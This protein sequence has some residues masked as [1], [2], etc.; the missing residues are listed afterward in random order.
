MRDIEIEPKEFADRLDRVTGT[1]WRP[2]FIDAISEF[3]A[4]HGVGA[5]HLISVE[6]S[7]FGVVN[8]SVGPTIAD[9]VLAK[10]AHRL[11]KIFPDAVAIG[12]LH[13]DHFALAFGQ[14]STLAADVQKLID[15]MQRPFA[16]NG[17]VIVLSVRVGAADAG[18]GVEDPLELL[19]AAE[20]ALHQT[21]ADMAKV[22]FFNADML[23]KAK[24][25]HQ[26]ENDLRL[27]LAM[28]AAELHRALNDFEFF[29]A[30]QPII[31]IDT[32]MVHAMEALL[33]W[34]H[35]KKGLVPPDR[36]I[37]LAEDIYVMDLLGGWV[38]RRACTDAAFWPANPDGTTPA[39]SI[40][41]SKV[42]FQNADM[43]LKLLEEALDD[44]L[45][46]AHRVKIEI[47]EN[48][49]DTPNTLDT[50]DRI[51]ALGCAIALDDFGSGYSSLTQLQSLSLDYMKVDQSFVRQLD[52]EDQETSQRA[53]QLTESVIKLGE[54]M[55]LQTI[56]EGVENQ[57]QLAM[58]RSMGAKL[59]QGYVYAMP[60]RV[61][62]VATFIKKRH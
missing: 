49:A 35:P 32:G 6:I 7:R 19:H 24:G 36:F 60:M 51:R 43:L 23:S 61:D 29:V 52:S 3:S 37:P 12:R 47:T 18:C 11:M 1:L 13:G 57:R 5:L 34:R 50:I 31:D 9:K 48:L 4:E 25:T 8:N 14:S 58:I 42:Q 56:V 15:F 44:T 16:V 46:P 28:N 20:V 30:Y 10:T 21:K 27:S 45:L 62:E 17:E 40:N 38:L 2:A 41:V 22:S 54:V 26:L 33:R 39:V 55:K 53:A 59:V